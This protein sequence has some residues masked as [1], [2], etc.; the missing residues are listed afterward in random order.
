[1]AFRALST[2]LSLSDVREAC[3]S[4]QLLRQKARETRRH[5]WDALHWRYFAWN[6]PSWVLADLTKAAGADP[7]DRCFTSLA[8]LHYARR[9]RLTFDF[10]TEKLWAASRSGVATVR[11]DHVLDYLTEYQQRDAAARRWRE[12]TRLK[13]ARNTLS[14]L[15][16]FGLLIG[17]QRKALKRPVVPPE[18]AL[19]LC[20]LL[21]AEGL[22]GRALLDARDWRLFLWDSQETSQ[23]L[24][25]LAQHGQIRF[26]RSGRTTIL[27]IPR[28][29]KGEGQ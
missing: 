17:V 22:C 26:E 10:V 24:G 6:P 20:R 15:R 21:D 23:A 28:S 16:D 25:Q 5:I 7:G 11:R 12:S 13:L 14:A 29:P 8:Y 18:V 9:D 4:G 3:L 19:H 2:G 1:M 27:E